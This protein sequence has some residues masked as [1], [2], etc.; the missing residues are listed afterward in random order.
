MLHFYHEGF[1]LCAVV[2]L[3]FLLFL[4][5]ST[6]TDEPVC[7]IRFVHKFKAHMVKEN[8][9]SIVATDVSPMQ[10]LRM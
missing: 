1:L 5:S 2:W 7:S 3:K 10:P 4:L 8:L 9:Y 6:T